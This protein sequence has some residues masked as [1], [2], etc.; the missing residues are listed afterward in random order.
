MSSGQNVSEFVDKEAIQD[1]VDKY[2]QL[3]QFERDQKKE[4]Q[5]QN[6]F[7]EPLFEALG[8]DTQDDQVTPEQTTLVGDADYSLSLH[9]REQFYI[10]AKR[11][12]KDL[13]G[14]R[15]VN[16]E[17]QSFPEQ[18]IDY[19]WH[20]RVDWA[21][22]TNFEELRLY[23]THV[24][25]DNPEDGLVFKLNF[26][27]FTAP[28]GLDRLSKLA[29]NNVAEGSL[30]ALELSR[31]RKPITGE[32][33]N[34]L[35]D[36]RLR[37]TK[38]IYEN[39]DDVQLDE[40]RE[41]VQRILDRLV[42][43]R[44]AA[45]RSI[46]PQRNLRSRLENWQ[47]K[48]LDKELEPLWE[49]LRSLFTGFYRKFG[50]SLFA[51]HACDDLHVSNE[52][53]EDLI[54]TLDEYRFEVISSDIL[55][56]IYEDYLGH[57]IEERGKE[58]EL[59]SKGEHRWDDG[60]Y[61]TPT[62]VVEYI[63]EST[64]GSH[65]E[66]IMSDVRGHLDQDPADFEAAREAFDQIQQV[67][68]LDNACGSGTFL[69]KAYDQFVE[70]YEEYKR[71]VNDAQKSVNGSEHGHVDVS[72]FSG[73]QTI[74]NY[75]T[76]ILENNI[77]GVDRDQQAVEIASMNL[78]LRSLTKKNELPEMIGEN[79]QS[80]NS[81]LNGS[82]EEVAEL[83]G[84]DVA[85]NAIDWDQAFPQVSDEGGFS[86]IVG[87]PPWGADMDE[88]EE[89]LEESGNYDLATGQYNSYTMFLELG[90]NLLREDGSL[91]YI[92]PDS[93]FND[94]YEGLRRWLLDN[95]QVNEVHKMGEGLFENVY[96]PTAI[97]RFTKKEPI[98][99]LPV[100]VSILKKEDR[101]KIMG[102]RNEALKRIIAEKSDSKKQ[103]RFVEDDEYELLLWATERDYE[104]MEKMH[105]GTVPWDKVI[106]NGRGDETGKS[107]NIMKCPSCMSWDSYPQKIAEHKGGGY[108]KKTCAHCGHEYKFED[109]ISKRQIVSET[110]TG[111]CDR[112]IYWGEDINRYR[113]EASAYIDDSYSDD[114]KMKDE[115]RFEPPKLMIRRSSFGFFATIDYSDARSLKANLVFRPLDDREDPF[116][117]Y[118][119][120]YFLGFLN[121]RTML[122][123]WSKKTNTVEWQSH[124]RHTQT[125][126]MSLPIPEVDWSD[127]SQVEKYEELV[128]MVKEAIETDGQVDEE[129]DWDIER[130]VMDLYG[131][132]PEQRQRITNELK[133]VQ[134]MRIVRELFPDWV[135]EEDDE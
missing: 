105:E 20:R 74:G 65:L 126:I 125:F 19:A 22:L 43:L 37:L 95:H 81:L 42:V 53:L 58:L 17:E 89:W 88:Y 106:D 28:H 33:L 129:L 38:D 117:R 60:I 75:E 124:I 123:Y 132:E 133:K 8:W 69:I 44:F 63:V 40:V 130:A 31:E 121:S 18:A 61:Y 36:F 120:E 98:L 109:A 110:K 34:V 25:K 104:I 4:R 57:A 64:V 39:N 26:K 56:S 87:N 77:Y 73:A 21:V 29:K 49:E 113:A 118:D 16:G 41:S 9:G 59:I 101:K 96:H 45:D 13:D 80:G 114:L 62:P 103:R 82:E 35:S 5:V 116:D 91:G 122:Y 14:T 55:G 78:I 47:E 27:E 111:D 128:E 108:R 30:K 12:S 51:P 97:L 112:P 68:V 93:I 90:S 135:D 2:K 79:L 85:S 115:W 46:I 66:S 127:E 11:F 48:S 83:C 131:F 119:L 54:L 134:K 1:L 94:D 67:R 52:V 24:S 7:I 92:I 23:W 72:S 50:T 84:S 3:S 107:G 32:I 70:C 10:E 15:R 86:C 102:P 99:E 71:L 100:R 6:H 76:D